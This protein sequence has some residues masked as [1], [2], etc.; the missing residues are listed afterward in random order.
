MKILRTPDDEAGNGHADDQAKKKP[1]DKP[2]DHARKE[3]E[4]MKAMKGT[5][6]AREIQLEKELARR[7]DREADLLTQLEDANA[8]LEGA[9]KKP[10][11]TKPG[12][13][14]LDELNEFLFGAPQK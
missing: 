7:E 1:A 3:S 11:A 12:K 2:A 13:T 8:L 9:R 14:V 10:S 6:T 5:K 4:T